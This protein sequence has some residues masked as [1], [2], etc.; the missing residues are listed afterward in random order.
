VLSPWSEVAVC[1]RRGAAHRRR[2]QPC[3]DA[4]LALE[5]PTAGGAPLRL[6][7]VADGHGAALHSRSQV[8]SELACRAAAIALEEALALQPPPFAMEKRGASDPGG[9]G[10]EGWLAEGWPA[11]V[12]HHWLALTEAHWRDHPDPAAPTY[13]PIPYGT[14]LGLLLLA[15]GWWAHA[16]LG[17]W[18]LVR[19]PAAGE[20]QLL[21]QE[22]P[23]PGGG[24]QTSSLCQG[25]SPPAGW[26][27]GWEPVALGAAPF[28]LV[29]ST[30]GVRK[31]CGSDQDFRVLAGWLASL[32]RQEPGS[33]PKPGGEAGPEPALAAALDHISAEGCGD[34]GSVAIAHWGGPALAAG[35][36]ASAL[37]EGPGRAPER[38]GA[39]GQGRTRMGRN[40]MGGNQRG[41][42]LLR[43]CGW[44][45]VGL[46]LAGLALV[47][48]GP[49]GLLPG[50]L[51]PR[52]LPPG[53]AS[54]PGPGDPGDPWRREVER[55]CR[56]PAL[57]G[58]TLA[59]RRSQVEALRRGT[60][61]PERLLAERGRDPL[62]AL[63]AAGFP[64]TAADA[65][66]QSGFSKLRLC[67]EL[68][69]A[70]AHLHG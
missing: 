15:P 45:L 61:R 70:L 53:V 41:A 27:W 63:I 18:D 19:I 55:L 54:G 68:R 51:P 21:S 5:L 32:A 20:G 43:G 59:S 22:P 33:G 11:A 48:L 3:Q 35:T 28:A 69:H 34:D 40:R 38:S 37:V 52:A 60:L 64:A 50:A 2:G 65:L 44:G 4:C 30:D 8:G 36:G 26:R 10:L 16:G 12:Q 24:E 7:A 58:P 42:R 56:E 17:D 62:G 46:A 57:L 49:T 23:F 67:A 9:E 6:L 31:S 1:S 39:G 66:R 25:G 14:T 29:L 13:S 47:A